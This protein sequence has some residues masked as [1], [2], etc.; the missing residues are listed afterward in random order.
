MHAFLCSLALVSVRTVGDGDA[1]QLFAV[2]YSATSIGCAGRSA[3]VWTT[4]RAMFDFRMGHDATLRARVRARCFD[5]SLRAQGADVLFIL[6]LAG[7]RGVRQDVGFSIVVAIFS[8]RSWISFRF[9]TCSIALACLDCIFGSAV[10]A[11]LRFCGGSWMASVSTGVFFCFSSGVRVAAGWC[12]F[13]ERVSRW[14]M[15][16][17]RR[18]WVPPGR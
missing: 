6:R 11:A 18:G 15:V 10:V 2:V 7:V 5:G 12:F 4:R 1:A 13:L 3:S 17:R 16:G 9:A 8:V 14:D